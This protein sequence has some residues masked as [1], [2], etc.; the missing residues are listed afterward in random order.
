[1]QC[2]GPCEEWFMSL[3]SPRVDAPPCL[4]NAWAPRSAVTTLLELCSELM[5]PRVHATGSEEPEEDDEDLKEDLA[6]Y[7]ANR[8]DDDD[9]EEEEPSRDDADDEDQDEDEDEEEEEEHPAPADSDPPVHS[10]TA[11]ISI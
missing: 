7:P 5:Y 4:T 6:D 11:R 9:E 3:I 10:M 2:P 1:M 8:D